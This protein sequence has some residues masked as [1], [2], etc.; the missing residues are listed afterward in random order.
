MTD[1]EMDLIE[2]ND[3]RRNLT[4]ALGSLEHAAYFIG[5]HPDPKSVKGLFINYF[6]CFHAE[7]MRCEKYGLN[8]EKEDRMAHEM[9]IEA[10]N[11]CGLLIGD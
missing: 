7:K 4:K 6:R 1:I 5:E 8:V 3:L 9:F 2:E 11:K 10:Y